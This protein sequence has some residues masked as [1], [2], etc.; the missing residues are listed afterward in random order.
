MITG[1]NESKALKKNMYHAIVNVN[2]MVESVIQIKRGI[3]INVDTNVKNIIYVKKII[4]GILLHVVA[5]TVNI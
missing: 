2:L 4:F 1:I 5:K 3:M